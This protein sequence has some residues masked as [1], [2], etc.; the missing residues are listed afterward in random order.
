MTKEAAEFYEKTQKE[1]QRRFLAKHI[2]A[3]VNEARDSIPS[4]GRRWPFELLQNALDFGPRTGRS[5]VM[6]SLS[7]QREKVLFEHDGIP[8]SAYDL[9]ALLSGGSNKD[10]ESEE[11]TGR[12]GTG[13]L[14]T[15]V[16]AERARLRGLL[17][18]PNGYEQFDLFLDRGGDVEA[19]LGNMKASIS[20]IYDAIPVQDSDLHQI[21]SA[22]FEYHIDDETPL[23]LGIDSLRSALPYLFAT[24]QILGRVELQNGKENSEIWQ[25]GEVCT[26]LFDNS[27]VEGRSLQIQHACQGLTEFRTFRFKAKE[28]SSASALVLV[29]RITEGWKVVPPGEDD[30]IIYREYPLRGSG[31]L[32][33]NFVLD[34]KFDPN[35]DRSGLLMNEKSKELIREAFNAAVMAVKFAFAQKWEDAHLLA[36]VCMPSGSFDTGDPEEKK[37]WAEQLESFAQR[38]AELPI[39]AGTAQMLP[40]ISQN[41]GTAD[42][43]IPSLFSDS[44]VEETTVE[45]MWP[46]IEGATDLLPPRKELASIWTDIAKGWHGLGVNN[47]NLISVEDLSE[48]VRGEADTLDQLLVDENAT[49]WLSCFLDIVGECWKSRSGVDSSMLQGMLPDQNQRLRSPTDLAR[50]ANVSDSLKD[51]CSDIGVDI[52]S[53]LLHKGVQEVG[54]DSNLHNLEYA[55]EKAV[56]NVATEKDVLKE[57]VERLRIRLPEDGRC[58]SIPIAIQHGSVRLLHY[59][60]E[61]RGQGGAKLAQ[62]VPIITNANIARR[63]SP[64]RMMMS[65]VSHWHESARP[66]ANAYPPNRVLHEMYTGYASGDIPNCVNA[67]VNWG[68]AFADPISSTTPAE[69]TDK[70]LA[71]LSPIDTE[72]ITVRQNI[73]EFSQIALLQPALLN[74]SQAG[75]EEA[76]ALFGLVLCHVAPHDSRWRKKISVKGRQDGRE[77][78][79]AVADALWLADLKSGAWVPQPGEDGKPVPTLANAKTLYELL[80]PSW[81]EKNDS[82]IRLLSEWFDF[83][84][85][86]LR[87]LGTT[88]DS[89][90]R[91][92]L[93]DG[94]ASL[95]EV[96]GANPAFYS[97]LSTL[98]GLA[99]SDMEVYS[100]LTDLAKLAKSG[101]VNLTKLVETQKRQSRDINKFRNLGIGVQ[102]AIKVALENHQLKL[103]LF[104]IGFDYEVNLPDGDVQADSSSKIEVGPYLLEVKATT[105]GHAWM[106]PLQAKTA[107]EEAKRYVLCVVDLRSMQNGQLPDTW[108]ASMVEPLAKIVPDIGSRIKGTYSL[109]ENASKR[110][111]AVRNETALRYEV[112]SVV[113]GTGKSIG[114]WVSTIKTNNASQVS[115]P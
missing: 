27:Y 73:A 21:P 69:L 33:T 29:E 102:E 36:K 44:S 66:F 64:T 34:G 37:W 14:V 106:T 96:G 49:Q 40:A 9:D 13:F 6:V 19:I 11:T 103:K 45:R 81:L 70:R 98:A 41:G 87:L 30:P 110:E 12:F 86:D 65:P 8:F 28:D 75:I 31:F 46:L 3:R 43:I 23:T 68:I 47:L 94:L 105:T 4:A 57:A 50:D 109:V 93:R 51:I 2:F 113:W 95:V 15:H 99:G 1:S 24:R 71:E 90:E 20:A 61:T 89:K 111:I 115:T 82:A 54:V 97:S 62:Q 59:I 63:W 91:E 10:F 18:A 77:I 17:N 5:L 101:D 55:L 76:R 7:S 80:E 58:D 35:E 107:S 92:Q 38:V 60:W 74:R 84:Q 25:P 56:P 88:P 32:P 39:V 78:E 53:R 42:F 85:L 100:S 22:R 114:E 83:D 48:E 79:I 108:S 72:G 67:L 112:P 104:D 52:R 16:L 26:Y